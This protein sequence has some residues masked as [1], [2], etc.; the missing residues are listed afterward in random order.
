[1]FRKGMER[2]KPNAVVPG[3]VKPKSDGDYVE[4]PRLI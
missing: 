1:M 3:L 2:A 4:Q